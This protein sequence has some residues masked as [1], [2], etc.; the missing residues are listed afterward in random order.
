MAIYQ[1]MKQ[2]M[3]YTRQG[4]SHLKK[5]ANSKPS[6]SNLIFF[7]RSLDQFFLT[8]GQ[9]NFRNKMTFSQSGLDAL[10]DFFKLTAAS[11]PEKFREVKSN[12]YGFTLVF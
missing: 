9:N 4:P 8:A 1:V 3:S 2:K 7:S 12:Q 10:E 6:V 11:F 5:F